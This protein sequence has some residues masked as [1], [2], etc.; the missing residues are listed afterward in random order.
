MEEIKSVQNFSENINQTAN[1]LLTRLETFRQDIKKYPCKSSTEKK[2]M[3]SLSTYLNS[4]TSVLLTLSDFSF[5]IST[6]ENEE[7]IDFFLESAGDWK[8]HVQ[9]DFPNDIDIG[10]D[11]CKDRTDIEELRKIFIDIE[12]DFSVLEGLSKYK[13]TK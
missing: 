4:A 12:P 9:T 2:A 5:E 11:F 10:S 3:N 7:D 8:A 13:Y 1:E 6:C